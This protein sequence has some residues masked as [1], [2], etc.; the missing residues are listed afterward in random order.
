MKVATVAQVRVAVETVPD[1]EL[2]AVTL[3]MLGMV[4]DLTVDGQG[5]V[6]VDLL[7]T[8]AGCPA[9]DMI[10]RDVV[11]AVGEVSGVTDVEVV[12]RYSPVWTPARINDQGRARLAEFGIAPPLPADATAWDAPP[13]AGR[14]GSS[15]VVL[16]IVSVTESSGAPATGRAC[17]WCSSTDTERD[18]AFGPT[19]CR[20]LWMCN[21]CRQPFEGFKSVS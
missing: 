15:A 7:P 13:A 8:F 18:S 5:R 20:D 16:P 19:P 14:A 17:P 1:P 4:H 2:P 21:G 6:A 11:T 3:G 12:F 9:I 10:R